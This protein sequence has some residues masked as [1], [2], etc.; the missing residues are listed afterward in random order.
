MKILMLTRYGRLGAS[1]RIRSYQYVPYLEKHGVIV[2]IEPLFDD[3]YIHNLYRIRQQPLKQ[4]TGGSSYH[5]QSDVPVSIK[6]KS[7]IKILLSYAQRLK[8]LCGSSK[9]DLLWIEKELFPWLPAFAET[10]LSAAGIPYVIDIDDAIFHKYDHHKSAAVRRLLG[11]KMRSVMRNAR[12]V[13]AGNPYLEHYARVSGAGSVE[14]IPTVV[15][16]SRYPPWDIKKEETA[17]CKIGWIGSPSTVWYLNSVRN[18]LQEISHR[19]T[20]ELLNV[21]GGA[22]VDLGDIA[23]RMMDWSEESE[24]RDIQSFDIGIMPLPDSP[25]ERGKCGYKL[26][27]YMACQLPVVASPVGVNTLIVEP[28]IN[29]FLAQEPGDWF[30]ALQ[31]LIGNRKMR[32]AMGVEGRRKVEKEY[33]LGVWGDRLF[34]ILND[35]GRCR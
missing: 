23:T 17:A 18:V 29:G 14:I 24:V 34:S 1:S 35:A 13:I 19:F 21:G 27:Q 15:D 8:R 7:V 25:Y 3:D 32:A 22:N 4:E 5:S 30:N 28:G 31:T 33:C 12:V 9:Y 11:S 6:E 10:I 26:I 20:V 2:D 16:L